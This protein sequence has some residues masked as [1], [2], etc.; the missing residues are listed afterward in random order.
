METVSEYV[1]REWLDKDRG[2]CGKPAV[3]R[4]KLPAGTIY[5]CARHARRFRADTR[6]TIE[7]LT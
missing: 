7:E 6:Y 2:E 5:K 1:C 4:V 3:I